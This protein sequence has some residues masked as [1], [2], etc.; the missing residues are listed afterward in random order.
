MEQSTE[1]IT[2]VNATPRLAPP[3]RFTVSKP[4][5][6]FDQF[7]LN[8]TTTVKILTVL[9]H[10]SLSLQSHDERS[11]W[12]IILDTKMDIEIDGKR[13]TAYRGQ[14][15]FIPQG[16]KHRALGL[17]TPCR[18]LEIAFGTFNEDDI[19]RFE[20]KYGRTDAAS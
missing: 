7:T 15:V 3:A 11:E 13:F 18:W 1:K 9:P 6:G 20:D 14:D 4:W 16:A 12:W 19:H 5:G 10:E 17:D 2:S 8:E